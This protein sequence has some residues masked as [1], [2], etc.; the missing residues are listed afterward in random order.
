MSKK[1]TWYGVEKGRQTGVTDN[2]KM[3]QSQVKGYSN[4]SSKKF[5][6]PSEAKNFSQGNHST[7][8]RK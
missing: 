5:N 8:S 2:W 3:A 1:Q 4:N 6:T 7:Q